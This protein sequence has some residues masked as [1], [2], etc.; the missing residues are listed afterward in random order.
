MCVQTRRDRQFEDDKVHRYSTSILCV[1]LNHLCKYSCWV[2]DSGYLS[3]SSL[4]EV[5]FV[6]IIPFYLFSILLLRWQRKF[7][8]SS[9]NNIIGI[10]SN[11][12]G[13]IS[14]Y[15]DDIVPLGEDPSEQQAFSII[16]TTEWLCLLWL[17]H[18]RS[19]S[20]IVGLS[21]LKFEP[22]IRLSVKVLVYTTAL[23]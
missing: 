17:F 3:P 15:A 20:D 14:E 2:R 6:R 5:L 8:S 12:K 22:N 10:C 16:W 9:E 19:V 11:R 21:W 18:L 7:P 23:K 4:Q 13:F 1:R